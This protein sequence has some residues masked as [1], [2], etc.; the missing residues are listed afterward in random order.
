MMRACLV[1]AVTG[2]ALLASPARPAAAKDYD[3]SGQK[4][5]WHYV[6]EPDP[7]KAEEVLGKILKRINNDRLAAKLVE[8]LRKG[9]A[10]P[11]G[12]PDQETVKVKCADGASRQFTYY[13]PEKYSGKKPVGVLVFLHGAI[14]Q[15]AP[16]GGA[17]EAKEL[18]KAVEELDM[19][20]IGPST[21]DGHEWGEAAVRALVHESLEHVKRRYNVDEDRVFIAGDSDGG[22][23]TYAMV[24]TEATF[25]AAA[26]PVI[27]SPGGVSR[28]VNLRN[29]PFLAM[30]GGKDTIFDPAHV[31]EMVKR[32][33]DAKIP[34]TFEFYEDAPHDPFLFVKHKDLV[35]KFLKDHPRN[36]LPTVV[37]WQT[38]PARKDYEA[39]FPANTFR[40]VRIEETGDT[41]QK[42]DFADFGDLVGNGLPRIR[43]EKKEGNEVEVKTHLVKR[44]TLLVSDAMFD[45]TKPI[46]VRVNGQA[47]VE[48]T[49]KTDARVALEEMRRLNDRRLVFNARLAFEVP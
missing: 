5:E 24:E 45:L 7:A 46:V 41:T 23:G 17:Y 28:F 4:P 49:V 20:R 11:Q 12:M 40:W 21:Y 48:S 15:P 31:K 2:L 33:T 38:D 34:L 22:R 39:G 14:R 36:P 35:Q 27:G 44:F 16:G 47:P 43:V 9:R 37:E 6:D 13:L 18:G 8:T 26:V 25:Y 42:G 10:Y 3:V 19:I 29:V 1:V 32:M 30:N